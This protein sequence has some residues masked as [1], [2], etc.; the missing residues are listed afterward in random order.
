VAT[1]IPAGL[2]C[3]LGQSVFALVER[4]M[5]LGVFS[6]ALRESAL[7]S[8]ALLSSDDFG[9]SVKRTAKLHPLWRDEGC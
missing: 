2:P 6:N 7:A 9:S 1:P 8:G 4:R 3:C 5:R